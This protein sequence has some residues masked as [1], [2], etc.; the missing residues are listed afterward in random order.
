MSPARF[1]NIN[2]DDAGKMAKVDKIR[3]KPPL[4]DVLKSNE[5]VRYP[6][7]CNSSRSIASTAL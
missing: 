7:R 2:D 3:V 6:R 5:S 1:G 4:Q